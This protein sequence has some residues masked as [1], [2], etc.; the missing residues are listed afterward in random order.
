M[1]EILLPGKSLASLSLS[2]NEYKALEWVAIQD[3]R[4]LPTEDTVQLRERFAL[5]LIYFATNG[6]STWTSKSNW[7]TGV[8]HCLWSLVQCSFG[9]VEYLDLTANG[10]RGTLPSQISYLQNLQTFFFA[11]NEIRGTI[12][13]TVGLMTSIKSFQLWTNELFGSIPSEIGGK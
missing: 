12:P 2:S 11:D 1:A 3:P 13:T 5:M 10:L 8:D 7:K 9:S 4:Q 6:D